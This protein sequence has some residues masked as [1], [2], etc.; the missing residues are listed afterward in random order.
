MD[1]SP[2]WLS[3]RV[4]LSA[5][6]ITA[7]LGVAFAYLLAK[8]R[9][10]GRGLLEAVASLPIVLPPTVLGYYLLT[11][12]GRRGPIGQAYESVVG[13]PLVFTAEGAVIAASVAAFPF[14]LRAARAAIADVDPRYEH[15]ARTMGLSERRIAFLVTLPLARSGILAGIT[16]AFAR[17]LGDFGT[18]LMV[19]G[20]IP[21]ETQT[22]P[23][24]VYDHVQAGQDGQAALLAAVLSAFAIAALVAVQRLDR[25][26]R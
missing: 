9:F 22:A 13:H 18:T 10:R 7:V 2:L 14:C 4:A 3:L 26:A 23:I 8:G 1:W 15:A 24:A 20:N 21:G 17:A 19:A 12:I 25:P 5:T 16:L 11:V 6:L